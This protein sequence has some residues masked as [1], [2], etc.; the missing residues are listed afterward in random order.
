METILETERCYLR[1]FSVDDSQAF[2]DLNSDPEVVKYTGDKAFGNVSEAR[3][4]LQNYNQYELYGF[5]RWAVIEK[6]T[7]KFIGWCG[8]KYSPDLHEVDL[9]FRFFRNYWNRGFATETA[10]AC[11]EY[12]FSKLNLDKIVGRAMEANI[13]S[14]KVLEKSGMEFVGKFEFDL[15]PGVLYQIEKAKQ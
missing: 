12:G 7:G 1:Q 4:F 15:H 11:L 14:V 2:Y 6:Q 8:L 3:S 10:L 9:G 13:G 5:G